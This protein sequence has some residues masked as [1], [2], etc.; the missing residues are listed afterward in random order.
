MQPCGQRV[1]RQCQRISPFHVGQLKS[2]IDANCRRSTLDWALMGQTAQAGRLFKGG[3]VEGER[4]TQLRI[5]GR[6]LECV[7]EPQ[8]GQNEAARERAMCK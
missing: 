2:V 4:K 3:Q 5:K 8:G 6:F 1:D 7:Q